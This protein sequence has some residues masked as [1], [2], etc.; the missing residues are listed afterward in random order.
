M[1]CA[2]CSL[3][4]GEFTRSSSQ[5]SSGQDCSRLL[6]R[7]SSKS[8]PGGGR[9]TL[10]RL[11]W[12][13]VLVM[14]PISSLSPMLIQSKARQS[15][16]SHLVVACCSWLPLLISSAPGC[17]GDQL[18]SRISTPP[19]S[20]DQPCG[21]LSGK[22][23]QALL[24]NLSHQ[25]HSLLQPAPNIQSSVC[26]LSTPGTADFFSAQLGGARWP[27]WLLWAV[28]HILCSQDVPKPSKASTPACTFLY[29]PA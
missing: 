17:A 28:E 29:T 22:A 20:G 15:A 26:H 7:A 9:G 18:P 27:A 14:H 21:E 8:I 5:S 19:H 6:G 25:S 11:A 13:M 3:Q 12:Q 24:T 23:A 2:A 1:P 10:R 16:G 4:M